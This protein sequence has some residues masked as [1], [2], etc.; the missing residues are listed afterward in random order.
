MKT[1]HLKEWEN[2]LNICIR[3][4]Y[5]FEGCPVFKELGWEPDGARGKAV[6]AYGLLT[7][8]LEPSEYIAEKLFQCSFC[9]DCIE[10]CSAN[11]EIP[12]ILAAARAD[13][14]EAGY[15]KDSQKRLLDT[16]EKSGNIFDK[17]LEAPN[18]KGEK[19]VLLGCRLLERKDD[20]KKYL[21]LL[22]KLGVKTKTF[23]ESCCGMPFA[24]LGDKKGF[25]AQQDKFRYTIPDR[26][27]EVICV[28]TTC[29][30]FIRKKYPDLKAKYIIDEIVERLPQYKDKI[31]KLGIKVTYHDPCNVARGMDM[32]DEPRMLL[33]EIG[34]ELIEM[35]TNGKQA[36]CCGG[37]GGLLVSDD[38]LA[39]KLAENRVEQAIE[40]GAEILTTLCPTCEFNLKNAAEK[41]NGKIEIV[42][43]LDL[44]YEALN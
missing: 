38:K 42:N 10:R 5:C 9:R 26:K 18:Y 32:V 28:C 43:L 37:G 36:E 7:G 25:K 6:L 30:F 13:L 8:E 11:V 3:C 15:V 27:E 34:A 29:V 17:E 19:Q 14:F 20:S 33:R 44:I 41:Y 31:K 40:T 22:E 12:D 2:E 24:V 23:N 16:I 35:P 4:A 1:N 21:D 39:E